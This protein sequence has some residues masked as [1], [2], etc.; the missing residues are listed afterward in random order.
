MLLQNEY[1]A[2]NQD[3][4]DTLA[5]GKEHIIDRNFEESM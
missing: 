1:K 3:R 4:I 5:L 2:A